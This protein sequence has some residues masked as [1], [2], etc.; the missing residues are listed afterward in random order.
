MQWLNERTKNL[1]EYALRLTAPVSLEEIGVHFHIG[2]RT[3]YN[4]IE[5]ANEW[6]SGC[7]FSKLKIQRGKLTLFPEFEI[8]AIEKKL[9]E[10]KGTIYILSPQERI[11]LIICLVLY[12]TDRVLISSLLDILEISRTSLLADLRVVRSF[13]K[14]YD[15][16]WVSLGKEGYEIE[17]NEIR[18][19]AVFLLLLTILPKSIKQ[20]YIFSDYKPN[21]D[22]CF[23]CLKQIEYELKQEYIED[24]LY[25]LASLI[26]HIK[27]QPKTLLF[28][29]MD[30]TRIE[31]SQEFSIIQKI[32]SDLPREEQ[33]YIALHILGSRLAGFS[34]ESIDRYDEEL[35]ELTNALIQEFEDRS[36]VEFERRDELKTALF[37]HIKASQ[38][39]YKYG[40]QIGS[41]LEKDI[42]AQYPEVYQIT[43]E[44]IPYLEQALQVHISEAEIA[45]LT[46][47]FGAFLSLP[48]QNTKELRVLI[49]CVSGVSTANMIAREIRMLLPQVKIV[50]IE[51]LRSLINPQEQADLIISSVEFKALIPVLK[52][53]PIFNEEDR[54]NVLNHPLISS[55]LKK[56]SAMVLY[57]KLK[58]LV[59]RAKQDLLAQRLNEYFKIDLGLGA[60]CTKSENLL[61]DFLKE[62][63][64]CFDCSCSWEEAIMKIGENLVNKGKIENRYL[65]TIIELTNVQGPYMFI[66]ENVV[67]AH[68]KPEDGVNKLCLGLGIFPKTISYCGKQAQFLFVLGSVDQTSHFPLLR[69]LRK[70]FKEPENRQSLASCRS[71]EDFF[72]NLKTLENSK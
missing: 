1:I 10:K 45:Y 59:P 63:T 61:G 53:H 11:Y 71:M 2:K 3:V 67:L 6:L 36:C 49:V 35:S 14:N 47:H 66:T 17:G 8:N 39:R 21:I 38:Y 5:R 12:K 32:F 25:D 65:E 33:I 70:V 44:V 41:P 29:D 42:R 19:R 40:I 13:L 4:E 22:E 34:N 68:A 48:A 43:K 9:R 55:F 30:G 28:P 31:S 72:E 51:S 15:L 58:D 57:E 60:S 16:R 50:G 27:R 26:S 46:L 23:K 54:R 64:L 18:R 20:N 56:G 69:T 62:N 7:Q 24:E 37:H 52:V